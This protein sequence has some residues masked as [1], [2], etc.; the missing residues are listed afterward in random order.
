MKHSKE[1]IEVANEA[2]FQG[3]RFLCLLMLALLLVGLSF[4]FLHEY[5]NT[6]CII[7]N[8]RSCVE[9]CRE[10][11]MIYSDDLNISPYIEKY[12]RCSNECKKI[13]NFNKFNKGD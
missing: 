5:R 4:K 8:Y 6:E 13:V 10:M 7:D 11:Q 3:W 1:Y 9:G 2:R 12:S